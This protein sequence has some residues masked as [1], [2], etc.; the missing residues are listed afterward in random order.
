MFVYAHYLFKS[1]Y[2]LKKNYFKAYLLW[3]ILREIDADLNGYITLDH[4]EN[5]ILK[6]FFFV[7]PYS[8]ENI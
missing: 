7:Q 3:I 6:G 8:E 2:I 1:L 5:A 4:K